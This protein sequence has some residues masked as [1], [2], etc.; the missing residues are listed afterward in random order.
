MLEFEK[1]QFAA[2]NPDLSKKGWTFCV[3]NTKT[4]SYRRGELLVKS[5]FVKRAAD[6]ARL[7]SGTN[8]SHLDKQGWK[9]DSDFLFRPLFGP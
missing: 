7:I 8:S 4:R 9:L 3:M 1:T 6:G 2:A 5:C